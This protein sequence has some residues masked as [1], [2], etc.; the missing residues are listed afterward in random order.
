MSQGP[1]PLRSLP[2][3]PGRAVGFLCL[4]L[5]LSGA[6]GLLFE[7]VWVRQLSLILGC[8]VQAVTAVF[9]AYMGGMAAGAWLLGPLP[10]RLGPQGSI[11]LYA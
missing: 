9:V 7:V 11:V 3:D 5:F 10:D 4:A 6:A 8:S 1:T 2:R